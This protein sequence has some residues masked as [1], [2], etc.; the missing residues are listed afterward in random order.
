MIIFD[1]DDVLVAF[2][3]HGDPELLAEL[4]KQR[5]ADQVDRYFADRVTMKALAE[6]L[7]VLD[8]DPLIGPGTDCQH[9]A[10]DANLRRGKRGVSD[11]PRPHH[12]L[13]AHRNLPWLAFRLGP[14]FVDAG[15]DGR[16]TLEDYWVRVGC[17]LPH[18]LRLPAI[19][20]TVSHHR[21]DDH[22]VLFV[23]LPP[24]QHPAEAH[25]AAIALS[26]GT[27]RVRYLTL[28]NIRSLLDG[29]RH[30]ALAEWTKESLQWNRPMPDHITRPGPE[31]RPDAFLS[32]IRSRLTD[33]PQPTS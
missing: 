7:D 1:W 5:D 26:T 11:G 9:T 15:R 6:F 31:P 25:F 16:L 13:F 27:G 10:A 33:Q 30:T 12:Y 17:K 20:L 23:A 4:Q 2:E 18:E 14:E 19:G 32:A 8:C 3:N 22:D 21:V 24:A 28:E 29:N